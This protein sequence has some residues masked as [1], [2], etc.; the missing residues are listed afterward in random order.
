MRMT[1]ASNLF[2]VC[3]MQIDY[4]VRVGGQTND[5]ISVSEEHSTIIDSD[6]QRRHGVSIKIDV[7]R[8]FD[9][10]YRFTDLCTYR[11]KRLDDN[12]KLALKQRREHYQSAFRCRVAA[13]QCTLVDR[14]QA[15]ARRHTL[16]V[17]DDEAAASV[18][19]SLC[20]AAP[21]RAAWL[22]SAVESAFRCCHRLCRRS[23]ATTGS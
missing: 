2:P 14:L 23:V 10:H 11:R 13:A 8:L 9:R 20:R 18:E 3:S 12:A 17:A 22:V 21:R 4:Y 16:L 7:H 6:R 1:S 19:R 15:G 5:A